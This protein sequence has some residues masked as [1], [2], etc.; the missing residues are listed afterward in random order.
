VGT[1]LLE[2]LRAADPHMPPALEVFDRT[3]AAVEPRPDFHE[4]SVRVGDR[5][6]PHRLTYYFDV[7][8]RGSTVADE[9]GARFVRLTEELGLPLPLHLRELVSS[10]APSGD[11][12]LQV[13]LGI[14]APPDGTSVRAK[15][16]LVFR[17][18]P[19]QT[20]SA[21]L[22]AAHLAPVAGSDPQKVYIVG[23]DV[24]EAGLDDIK[25]YFRLEP[26]RV[27]GLL[28]DP[29][30]VTD[31]LAAGHEI[32]FQQCTRRPTRRQMYVH[33]RSSTSLAQWLATHGFGDALGSA[34]AI[35]EHLNGSHLDP[36]IVSFAY[37]ERRLDLG[38]GNVYFHL[39]RGA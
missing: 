21:L 26:R 5:A 37:D 6:S 24:T 38:A 28:D 31:L 32:V 17:S 39:T 1:E 34:G 12:V 35:N 13:V 15:Y 8:R 30:E 19:G 3:V 16:Y 18:N 11:E 9:A 14:E 36:W 33:A 22:A 10:H 2:A 20:V 29:G 23:C 4:Y 7:H 25:L 27:S